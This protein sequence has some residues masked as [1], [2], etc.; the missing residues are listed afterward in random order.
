MIF[1]SLTSEDEEYKEPFAC[2]RWGYK[3]V[4]PLWKAVW[5]VLQKSNIKL[6]C[7]L[8]ILPLGIYLNE[9]KSLFPRNIHF[10]FTAV[11][12]P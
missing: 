2:S 3:L 6:L 1:K 9:M 4:Q 7:D 10:M 5:I 8:A 12:Y 11:Q